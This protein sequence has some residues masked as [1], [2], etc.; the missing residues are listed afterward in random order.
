MDV[1]SPPLIGH[2]AEKENQSFRTQYAEI[3]YTRIC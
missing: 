2:Q 1:G 3:S